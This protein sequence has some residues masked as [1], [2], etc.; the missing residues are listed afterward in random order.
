MHLIMLTGHPQAALNISASGTTPCPAYTAI[1]RIYVEGGFYVI[2]G[3]NARINQKEQPV[4]F[5]ETRDYSEVFKWVAD[6]FVAFYDVKDHR[7]WLV[8]GA[9]A[10]LH[11]V[12][13]SLQLDETNPDS[14]YHW[15]FEKDKLEEDWANFS[16]RAAS[17]RTLKSWKNR[18]LPVYIKNQT[19][20][21]GAPVNT[22]STF[23]DRVDKVLH[24]LELLIEHQTRIATESGIRIFQTV[25][26]RKGIL[27]FDILDLVKSRP[28]CMPRIERFSSGDNSWVS[29]LPA[30][31]VLTI[32]GNGFGDLI[33]PSKPDTICSAWRFV[34]KGQDYLAS[35]I[36][37]LTLLRKERL[38]QLKTELEPG[39]LTRK[40]F[41]RSPCPPFDFCQCTKGKQVGEQEHRN[42]VQYIVS[43][44]WLLRHNSKETT[45]VDVSALVST[46]AVV[47]VN[48]S[49]RGRHVEARN[50]Q[51]PAAGPVSSSSHGSLSASASQ[52]SAAKSSRSTA[53]TE[54]SAQIAGSAGD[55]GGNNAR[56]D[57][58]IS[59]RL[60]EKWKG[61]LSTFYPNLR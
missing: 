24:S 33:C 31:G 34:P 47:F 56:G 15:V 54:T 45:P 48:R 4:I 29:L 36:S 30:I 22:Y 7:G 52:S 23:G 8:D 38:Q 16:G 12:R 5:G 57:Q 61:K 39:G 18:A 43:K 41:W 20:S 59:S 14:T 42:P 44:S 17:I 25:D 51:A 27:G 37:T 53:P 32:F 60:K 28:Q 49:S 21:A 10:L 1:D 50:L 3:V 19:F 13:I 55:Q 2:G 46:G 6:Q 9:S 35:S 40:L 11:L 26:T 58:S